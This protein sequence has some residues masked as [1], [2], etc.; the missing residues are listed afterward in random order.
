MAAA[1]G[2]VTVNE[3]VRVSRRVFAA[4]GTGPGCEREGADAVAWLETRGLAGL[5][6]LH[7]DLPA[8]R[9]LGATPWQVRHESPGRLEMD[10]R[11]GSAVLAAPAVV[12]WLAGEGEAAGVELA[13]VRSPLWLLP[14]LAARCTETVAWLEARGPGLLLRAWCDGAGGFEVTLPD[15]PARLAGRIVDV[16]GGR[17]GPPAAPPDPATPQLAAPDLDRRQ[18]AALRDGL[19]VPRDLWHALVAVAREVLVPESEQSRARGA[20]GGDDNA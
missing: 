5:A 13:S 7:A 1:P 18:W 14:P 17:G 16:R 8:L 20:G 15:P 4:L 11:G 2:R 10:G 3:V 6:T 12:D 9:R 19:A